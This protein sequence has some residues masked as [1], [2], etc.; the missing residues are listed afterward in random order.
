[1]RLLLGVPFLDEFLSECFG[2][3]SI[4]TVYG[5]AATGKTLFCLLIAK[6]ASKI[7]KVFYIDSEHDFSIERFKQ[8]NKT[9]QEDLKNIIISKP[10]SFT[11]QKK[12]IFSLTPKGAS[13]II[14]DSITR[15]YQTAGYPIKDLERQ[16]IIIRKLAKENNIPIILTSRVFTD[17]E[18]KTY[19]LYGEQV[20]KTYSKYLL[21]LEKAKKSIIAEYKNKKKFFRIGTE[22]IIPP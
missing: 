20:I 2:S 12:I 8:I 11:E 19:H 6:S 3:G 10:K 18:K 22:G 15:H 16:L 17:P 1:M 13:A 9:W 5:P 21:K 7:G 14:V 4:T